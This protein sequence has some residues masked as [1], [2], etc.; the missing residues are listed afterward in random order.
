MSAAG[1][2]L[3]V[4]TRNRTDDAPLRS[5]RLSSRLSKSDG[6][7]NEGRVVS[8]SAVPDESVKRTKICVTELPP[9]RSPLYTPI[10]IPGATGVSIRESNWS[11]VSSN[12]AIYPAAE[13]T[14]ARP[15][16]RMEYLANLRRTAR[17]PLEWLLTGHG[18]PVLTHARLVRRRFA[19][20][21][22]RCARIAAALEPGQHSAEPTQ[23]QF[24]WHVIKLEDRRS[25]APASLEEIEPQLR[26]KLARGALEA[27]LD[28]LRDGAEIEI[29]S[30]SAEP[31]GQAAANPAP[32][33]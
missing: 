4:S 5:S 16:A 2:K 13:P 29:V 11:P 27:V 23:T 32:A 15:R 26:E 21:E 33:Q 3:N 6:S 18:D 1:L 10:G 20:H 7:K 17:M 8:V 22:R 31:S 28:A 30:E 19:E 9:N 25:G 14:G 12:T 24:G